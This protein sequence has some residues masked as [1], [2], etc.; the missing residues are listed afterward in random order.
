[1]VYH[2]VKKP[3]CSGQSAG[4]LSLPVLHPTASLLLA[5][6]WY[7]KQ[8]RWGSS[9]TGRET[10]SRHRPLPRLPQNDEQFG[11][12]L[13]GLIDSDG[14]FSNIPQCIIAFHS[15]DHH[16][17]YYIKSYVGYGQVRA[18][19]SKQAMIYVCS[20]SLGLQRIALLIRGQL[21]CDGKIRQYNERL[22][23]K[24]PHL[25]ITT[26]PTHPVVH[27]YW[28]A[29]FI[30]GDGSFQIKILERS[31][32]RRSL[33]EIRVVLQI[34]Q[35]SDSLLRVIQSS[36]GGSIGYRA[37]QDTYYYSTVSFANAAKLIEYCDHTH[38]IGSKMT[39]YV[40]W[41]RVCV[42]IQQRKHSSSKGIDMIRAIRDRISRLKPGSQ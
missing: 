11:S 13:A 39:Q 35:K 40:L 36:L 16:L 4:N 26:S 32:Q 34:D 24:Y 41:R 33:P 37:S 12:F 23:A 27:S 22:I 28:L 29:G 7:A 8:K 5:E 31:K 2:T 21:R 9:E 20:H 42:L 15:S 6:R 10:L 30:A 38:L 1:M 18:V 17:A 25:Q 14:H 3:S 19:K